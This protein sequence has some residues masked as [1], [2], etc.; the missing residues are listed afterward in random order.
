MF[1]SIKK[2]LQ[3][4]LTDSS[5]KKKSNEILNRTSK[6]P[7][8]IITD[9][10][11]NGDLREHWENWHNNSIK[12]I[13]NAS[14]RYDQVI[15]LR[16]A[17]IEQIEEI[18]YTTPVVSEKYSDEDMK[19]LLEHLYE[20]KDYESVK[21]DHFHR[22]MFSQTSLYVLR[23]ISY[24]FNDASPHDWTEYYRHLSDTYV[25][26]IYD[27]IIKK[28]KGEECALD[29]LT[30]A[31]IN[32]FKAKL[33]KTREEILNGSNYE[34]NFKEI[35]KK[36]KADK[37]KYEQKQLEEKQREEAKRTA[38]KIISSSQIQDLTEL[39]IERYERIR[40]GELYKVKDYSPVNACGAL[41]VDSG[42][43]LIA[44]SECVADYDTA[45]QGLR[46]VMWNLVKSIGNEQSLA[47]K[48]L[49]DVN[50][51]VAEEI[52]KI[53]K[54]NEDTG[55]M[56]DIALIAIQHLYEIKLS[57]LTNEE[58]RVVIKDAVNFTDDIWT[59]FENTKNVFSSI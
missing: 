12:D 56:P 44:L 1:S 4:I 39:M 47:E 35:E 57:D 52:Y 54:E 42:I 3:G 29:E 10:I 45:K 8:N 13:G 22:Y 48:S 51:N 33:D 7:G 58:Q 31:L 9:R 28:I 14:N 55:W 59:V 11:L 21:S 26:H 43:M 50:I 23:N 30:T 2:K 36:E 32:T 25:N 15:G 46:K 6:V 37:E 38:I 49:V 20:D 41:E 5:L 18:S 17:T 24:E 19:L 27:Q 40:N 53:K 16:R 34:Y